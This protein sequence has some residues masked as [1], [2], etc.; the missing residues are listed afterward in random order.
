MNCS[1]ILFIVRQHRQS[2]LFFFF[3]LRYHLY[4]LTDIKQKHRLSQVNTDLL[5]IDRTLISS[6]HRL[7]VSPNMLDTS[8]LPHTER[9]FYF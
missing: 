2:S 9:D 5:S 6:E 8:L 1:T 7:D 4:D 3:Q